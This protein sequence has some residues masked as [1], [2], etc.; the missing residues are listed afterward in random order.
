[1]RLKTAIACVLMSAC[2]A[3]AQAQQGRET[4]RGIATG[5]IGASMGGDV[6]DPVMTLGATVSVQEASGWGTEMDISYANDN[7]GT[8]KKADITAIMIGANWLRSRGG[9]VRPYFAF[10]IG[11]LGLHGCLQACAKTTT[12]WDLG[13][14]TGGGLQYAF[15]DIIGLRGDVR[16]MFAPGS[17]DGD[18]RPANWGF[19]RVSFGIGFGWAVQ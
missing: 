18:S 11:T 17:H 4:Y 5:L 9:P 3:T 2:A 14:S 1:M 7:N 6:A 19:W 13:V 16:Y 8:A 12:T 15:N 10:G